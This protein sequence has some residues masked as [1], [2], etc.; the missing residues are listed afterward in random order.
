[1]AIKLIRQESETPNITNYD[2]ARMARYAYGG[3]DGYVKSR[4]TEIAS[5]VN[6]TTFVVKSGVLVLQG[7]E[8]EIDANGV[9]ISVT[10][11]DASL[12][13]TVVYLE[14][15]RAA[16]TVQIKTLSDT[17]GYPQIPEND[18]LTN[19]VIGT[20]RLPLYRFT[21]QSGVIGN[22]EKLVKAIEYMSDKVSE[23]EQK[24]DELGFK[25]ASVENGE[26]TLEADWSDA[27]IAAGYPYGKI[28]KQ[29][30]CAVF[31]TLEAKSITVSN[32][33]HSVDLR[34]NIGRI[35]TAF[36]PEKD[37]TIYGQCVYY[38]LML[39]GTYFTSSFD[40]DI[41]VKSNGEMRAIGSGTNTST[42]IVNEKHPVTLRIRNAGWLL[43]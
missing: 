42:V 13:Y 22:V 11:A 35:P 21:T 33:N 25:E 3:Y 27:S 37:V 31:S 7:W 26:I 14:I 4:G 39:G 36:C 28:I 32:G 41:T 2:D 17:A 23:I 5:E 34:G 6:G 29:G 40:V 8:T 12:R 24:L 9:S 43:P 10:A 1:M 19:N 15:N 20:A 16:D 30:K 38:I 18:D